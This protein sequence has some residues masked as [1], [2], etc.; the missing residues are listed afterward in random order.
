MGKKKEAIHRE[1]A[2]R[3]IGLSRE[4]IKKIMLKELVIGEIY[5]LKSQH[6]NKDEGKLARCKLAGIYEH[7]AVFEH[8]DGTM[9]AFSYP[10]LW[11]QMLARETVI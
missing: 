8:Q 11:M 5:R 10:E 9:E 3:Y 7:L 6:S 2:M 1:G 4:N